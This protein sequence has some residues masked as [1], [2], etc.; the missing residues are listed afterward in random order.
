MNEAIED[1]HFY[2][3]AVVGCR[4]KCHKESVGKPLT[5]P[6]LEDMKLWE[7]LI[8]QTLC[9]L[10][11]KKDILKNRAE[12]VAKTVTADF[13]SLKPYDYMQLCY[14]KVLHIII[15]IQLYNFMVFN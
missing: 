6:Q 9:I 1:Y 8:K 14:Y 5:S 4:L 2:R 12:I 3:D 15:P 10:K 7:R 13:E 11:C